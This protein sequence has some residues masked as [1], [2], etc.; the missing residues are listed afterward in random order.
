MRR[1]RQRSR[2]RVSMM[3]EYIVQTLSSIRNRIGPVHK[4]VSGAKPND[5]GAQ[6]SRRPTYQSWIRADG[7]LQSSNGSFMRMVSSRSGLVESSVTGHSI[8][9]SMRLTYLIACAGSEPQDRLPSVDE[10]QPSSVS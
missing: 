10:F 7:E 4:F 8:N 1:P 3:L 6:P 9:S 5:M 2:L